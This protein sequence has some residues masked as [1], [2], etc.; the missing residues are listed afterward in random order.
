MGGTIKGAVLASRKRFV[1]DE[2]G[3]E[4]LERILLSLP[5]EHR[6]VLSGILLPAAWYPIETQICFDEAIVEIMGGA[7][8]RALWNL[9]RSSASDNL[10]RFHSAMTRGKTPLT[11]L[12][13]TPAIYRLYYGSGTREFEASGETSGAIITRDAQ[14]ASWADC[15]TVMGWH[16][17]AL[18]I[19]GATSVKI[20]H[21]VCRAKGG[22]V[23]RYEVSWAT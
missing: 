3:P 17:R 12:Q 23:C 9:G 7:G 8:E 10:E 13:Q 6:D 18:E 20:V 21:P 2:L 22:D 14:D 5:S 1:S 15:V 11:F 4:A 19:V 16:E